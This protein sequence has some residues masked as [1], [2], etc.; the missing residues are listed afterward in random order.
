MYTIDKKRHE[1]IFTIPKTALFIHILLIINQKETRFKLHELL[2]PSRRL[3][4]P[5]RSQDG[6]CQEKAGGTVRLPACQ[7][8]MFTYFFL[9]RLSMPLLHGWNVWY[10]K[11]RNELTE[12]VNDIYWQHSRILFLRPRVTR[13][14]RYHYEYTPERQLPLYNHKLHKVS[15][16]NGIS[17]SLLFWFSQEILG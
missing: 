8:H 10:P 15:Q 7:T 4:A 3:H 17:K 14:T 5:R 9:Q 16:L 6:I 11:Q 2:K 13:H 12:L 1:F